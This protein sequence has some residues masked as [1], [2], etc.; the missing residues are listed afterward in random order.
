MDRISLDQAAHQQVDRLIDAVNRLADEVERHNELI[1]NER[2]ETN[3][4]IYEDDTQEE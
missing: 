3:I 4:R 2:I 1:E